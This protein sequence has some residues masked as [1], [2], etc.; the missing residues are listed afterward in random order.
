MFLLVKD[1]TFIESPAVLPL[2]GS[3]LYSFN[4]ADCKCL[5][6]VSAKSHLIITKAAIGR[7]LLQNFFQKKPRMQTHMKERLQ[8]DRHIGLLPGL[9]Q[10]WTYYD[11]W[12]CTKKSLASREVTA[13]NH[14]SVLPASTS[15]PITSVK[16][17]G[18]NGNLPRPLHS[19]F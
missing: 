5:Y 3:I 12:D 18:P 11:L 19:L 7:P 15:L 6:S 8:A 16:A 1:E 9:A 2:L 17:L 4:R 14:F 13:R 10:A